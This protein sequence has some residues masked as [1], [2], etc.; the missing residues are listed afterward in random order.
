[1]KGVMEMTT[2]TRIRAGE[3]TG[4]DPHGD[5]HGGG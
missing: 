5:P 4:I 3:G 1:M 2:H